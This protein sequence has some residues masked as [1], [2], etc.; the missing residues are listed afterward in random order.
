MPATENSIPPNISC[1]INIGIPAQQF[2]WTNAVLAGVKPV[3]SI[4]SI[5]LDIWEEYISWILDNDSL[6]AINLDE[7]FLVI[8][9]GEKLEE[10]VS[11]KSL[12]Q[13]KPYYIKIP[14]SELPTEFTGQRI[15]RKTSLKKLITPK[16]RYKNYAV[17]TE[18]IISKQLSTIIKIIKAEIKEDK[19]AKGSAYG[20][21]SCCIQNYMKK[22]GV[23]ATSELLLS[24]IEKGIDKSIP[25]EIWVLGHIPCSINCK[26]SLEIGTRLL[27]TIKKSKDAWEKVATWL[28]SYHIN[29]SVGRRFIDYVP[30]TFNNEI[31]TEDSS[32]EIIVQRGNILRPYSYVEYKSKNHLLKI[33]KDIMG[34]KVI[35]YTPGKMLQISSPDKKRNFIKI[36]TSFISRKYRTRNILKTIFRPYSCKIN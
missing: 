35:K 36:D 2:I 12:S 28:G 21:P 15:I 18:I 34:E 31:R 6:L 23:N 30:K 19:K 33:N 9:S 17:Q 27:S 3:T 32:T 20:F 7:H 1:K 10:Q 16:I 13:D 11:A 8:A 22:G 4:F 26:Q 24:L 14:K 25:P 5:N 29:F